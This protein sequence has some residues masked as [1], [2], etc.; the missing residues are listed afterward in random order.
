M[1]ETRK[2]RLYYGLESSSNQWQKCHYLHNMPFLHLSRI[3][4]SEWNSK[5]VVF[6]STQINIIQ[7]LRHL[8]ESRLQCFEIRLKT[9][10]V[11]NSRVSSLCVRVSITT[12]LSRFFALASFTLVLTTRLMQIEE[13]TWLSTLWF[14]DKDHSW[15]WW[16][17][18]HERSS[19]TRASLH[20]RC[21][22]H[23]SSVKVATRKS[24]SIDW[25]SRISWYRCQF[26]FDSITHS[27]SADR[28]SCLR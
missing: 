11:S 5:N 12:H 17:R 28:Q 1:N 24:E 19:R 13:L 20:S 15:T 26:D 6:T 23:N 3:H 16:W 27:C 21:L 9:L 8:I 14:F 25:H 10:N 4:L 18:R 7:T 22:P 2:H